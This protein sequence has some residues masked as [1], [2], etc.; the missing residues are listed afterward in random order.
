MRNSSLH[1]PV[2]TNAAAL[3]PAEGP[4][5]TEEPV[6]LADIAT[7]EHPLAYLFYYDDVPADVV[8]IDV[9]TGDGRSPPNARLAL[10]YDATV[11]HSWRRSGCSGDGGG[12]DHCSH[13]RG[14]CRAQRLAGAVRGAQSV[15][16][17]F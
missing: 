6:L 4:R 11:L 2:N 1:Q 7:G 15:Q 17:L 16:V 12:F 13:S 3:A 14:V 8:D 9:N 5:M 10:S